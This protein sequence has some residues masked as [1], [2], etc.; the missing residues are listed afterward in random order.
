MNAYKHKHWKTCAKKC[1]RDIRTHADEWRIVCIRKVKKPPNGKFAL[2]I[3]TYSESENASEW[4]TNERRTEQ[5]DARVHSYWLKLRLTPTSKINGNKWCR[6]LFI[7]T[8]YNVFYF[9]VLV[10]YSTNNRV[11]VCRATKPTEK[12]RQNTRQKREETNWKYFREFVVSWAELSERAR[13]YIR[14]IA[15]LAHTILWVL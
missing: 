10:L 1:I 13:N 12:Y 11:Y 5:T 4:R 2:C 7:D 9:N 14:M 15:P 8:C 6:R 3:C